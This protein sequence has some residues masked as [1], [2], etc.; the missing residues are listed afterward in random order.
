MLQAL[1]AGQ[2]I[3]LFED[4][5]RSPLWLDDAAQACMRVALDTDEITGVLHVPG[6]QGM[7]RLE[8]GLVVAAAIGCSSS[9]L[10][11][12]KRADL[13]GEEPRPH[14]LRL[15]DARYRAHFGGPAGRDMQTALQLLLAR[16][17]RRLLS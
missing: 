8:M 5:L 12:A 14:D 1:R 17:P 11:A 15:D 7:S 9:P 16:G 4:E 6:P 3:Q 13:A 10:I 2:P